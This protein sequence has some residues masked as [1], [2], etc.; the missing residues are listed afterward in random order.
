MSAKVDTSNPHYWF[1]VDCAGK[2]TRSAAH[3]A[4]QAALSALYT[5]AGPDEASALI[6][7]LNEEG[8]GVVRL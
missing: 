6:D 3:S 2:A 5:G 4:V 8:W 1:C 7:R